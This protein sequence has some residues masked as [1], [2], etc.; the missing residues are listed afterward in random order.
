MVV[1]ECRV[2]CHSQPYTLDLVNHTIL[3]N[4][5]DLMVREVWGAYEHAHSQRILQLTKVGH[6]FSS[7]KMF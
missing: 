1:R 2:L 6:S 3:K 7:S 4:M 5:A